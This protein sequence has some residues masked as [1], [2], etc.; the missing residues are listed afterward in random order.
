MPN[1]NAVNDSTSPCYYPAGLRSA[2]QDEPAEGTNVKVLAAH[3]NEVLARQLAVFRGYPE[4]QGISIGKITTTQKFGLFI[5]PPGAKG[6][7]VH[8]KTAAVFS[9]TVFNVTYEGVTKTKTIATDEPPFLSAVTELTFG[10][11]N[12]ASGGPGDVTGDGIVQFLAGAGSVT[13]F[14]LRYS[15]TI[16]TT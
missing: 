13:V 7:L 5:S 16:N 12:L 3:H 6:V 8:F 1:Q 10:P 4:V 15:F 2:A 9:S 11:W 14:D